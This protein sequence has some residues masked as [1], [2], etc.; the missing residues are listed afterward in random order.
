[1]GLSG[2]VLCKMVFFAFFAYNAYIS[3]K[4]HRIIKKYV[5][6]G[7]IFPRAIIH[8]Q[9]QLSSSIRLEVTAV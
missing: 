2:W 7:K 9:F 1:M 6:F 3:G 4:N 5:T 8:E